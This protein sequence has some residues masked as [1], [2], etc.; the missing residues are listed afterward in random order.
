MIRTRIF[1]LTIINEVIFA[2]YI[3]SAMSQNN[4]KPSSETGILRAMR[5]KRSFGSNLMGEDPPKKIHCMK[6]SSSDK[7]QNKTDVQVCS[8]IK[9]LKSGNTLSKI[10]IAGTATTNQ[11]YYL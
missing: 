1:L 6:I 5:N 2:F 11:R 3:G 8:T 10:S 9:T 7:R 4:S